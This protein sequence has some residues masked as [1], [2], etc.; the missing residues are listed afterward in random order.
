[1]GC[2]VCDRCIPLIVYYSVKPELGCLH[3]IGIQCRVKCF[4]CLPITKIKTVSALDSIA[5]CYR[6]FA[7]R[8]NC[9]SKTPLIITQAHC[10]CTVQKK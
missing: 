10:D 4:L 3:H 7:P 1:M 2:F 9:G 6:I 8:Q 5:P